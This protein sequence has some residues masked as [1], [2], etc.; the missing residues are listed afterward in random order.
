MVRLTI[1]VRGTEGRTTL[2]KPTT[3]DQIGRREAD[4]EAALSETPELLCLESRRTGIYGPF[5]VF[6]QVALPTPLGREIY[7]DIVL[8]TA[9]GDVVIVEVKLFANPEIR[10]RS[11]IAQIIDYAS[12]ISALDEAGLVRLFGGDESEWHDFVRRY[13]PNEDD[14][15][16]LAETLR[17]N[18]AA[19]NVHIVI[20]CDKAPM[21][22]YDLARSVSS[23]SHLGFA[24]DV[25]E[26][27]PFVPVD[28]P[29][30]SVMFVP[31]VRLSTEIVARTAVSVQVD[32]STQQPV[33]S[34]ETTSVEEIEENLA[35]TARGGSRRNTGRMW[36][37]R[38]IEDVFVGS[39]DPTVRD[40]FLFAK[41]EGFNGRFQSDGPKISPAFGFYL[42]V[43]RPDGSE[44]GSQVFNCTDDGGNA[45]LVY[46][47]NWPA[48]AVSREDLEAFKGDLRAV[49]GS[50]VNVN[51]K[52]VKIP[53]PLLA[54]NV[55]AFKDV[56]RRM[57]GRVDPGRPA[58]SG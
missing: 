9:S 31:N 8:L 24:L 22:A 40:L 44:G 30:D 50:A 57:Q 42:R 58:G 35:A 10:D 43:R 55:D 5:A 38:E 48:S 28:G 53:L 49:F 36:S 45:I 23:Q 33:V 46:L 20:A 2:W 6:N 52:D 29:P 14:P 12:S 11:V 26:V 39:D 47:N 27:T 18:A 13:F 1:A 37:D 3:L 56:I 34:V 51:V 15:E 25:L 21:G 41:Q 19:G 54:E 4:L 17:S 16:E 7:P 32:S